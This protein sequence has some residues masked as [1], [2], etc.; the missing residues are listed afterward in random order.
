MNPKLDFSH[1]HALDHYPWQAECRAAYGGPRV[2]LKYWWD[3]KGRSLLMSHT[4]C[5]V[6]RHYQVTMT[7]FLPSSSWPKV[8]RSKQPICTYCLKPLGPPKY[9]PGGEEVDI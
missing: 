6:G 9:N 3:F 8:W 2:H 7:S 4:L 1:F 5:R